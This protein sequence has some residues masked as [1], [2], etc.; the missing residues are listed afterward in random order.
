[1]FSQVDLLT[2]EVEN[3]NRKDKGKTGEQMELVALTSNSASLRDTEPLTKVKTM[4][5]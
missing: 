4:S 2:G 1:M 3:V 5:T